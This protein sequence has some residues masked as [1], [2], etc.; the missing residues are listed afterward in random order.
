MTHDDTG[1]DRIVEQLKGIRFLVGFIAGA[2]L[3][4]VVL[5]AEKL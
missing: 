5:L 3:F 4:L 1:Y 2:L